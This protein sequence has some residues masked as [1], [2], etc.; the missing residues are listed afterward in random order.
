MEQNLDLGQHFMIDEDLISYIVSKAD[1]S[2]EDTILEI[3]SGEGILSK[4][5]LENSPNKLIC[6]EIDERLNKIE[7]AEY[8]QGNILKK[9][10]ILKFN[11]IISNIPYHISEP[12]FSKLSIIKTDLIVCTVGNSFADKLLD[13]SI[14]GNILRSVYDITKDKIIG[15]EVF[16]PSPKVD[17][18]LI[19]LKLKLQ[20]PSDK[21]LSKFHLHG[22]SKIKNFLIK[23]SEEFF[24]KKELRAKLIK[25]DLDLQEKDLYSLS[26][27]DFLL[28]RDF[29]YNELF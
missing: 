3:G 26:T 29:I 6:V 20:S 5:I 24:S 11:K 15:P 23:S 1:I 17:S 14:I 7:G 9:L 10:N 4:K 19:I 16:D 13:E 2:E 27:K 12:L 21:I 28:M 8:I 22:A 18:A 25:M